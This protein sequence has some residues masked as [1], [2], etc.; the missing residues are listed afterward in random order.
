MTFNKSPGQSFDNVGIY[1]P[2]TVFSYDQL[3]V[4]LARDRKK[5]K[6]KIKI[7]HP[8]LKIY[9]KKPNTPIYTKNIVFKNILKFEL[10]I[11]NSE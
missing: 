9:K 6:I 7:T 3:Y 11:M 8:N 10:P 5:E 1:L 4:A 2:R